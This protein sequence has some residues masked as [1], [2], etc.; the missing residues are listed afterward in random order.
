MPEN[1]WISLAGGEWPAGARTVGMMVTS[2]DGTT[3]ID[4]HVGALTGPDDQEVL[5]GAREHADVV[6]AGAAT[7]AAEGYEGL[8]G[9]DAKAR[10]QERGLRPEPILAI[11]SLVP[12]TLEGRGVFSHPGLDVVVCSPPDTADAVRGLGAAHLATESIVVGDELVPDTRALVRSLARDHGARRIV[13]EGGPRVLGWT[14]A[15]GG[16]D[17]CVV[18]VSPLIH[19]G[20]P[21]PLTGGVDLGEHGARMRVGSNITRGDFIFTRYETKGPD[22][23]K[24]A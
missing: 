18:V 3:M 23:P 1:L 9:D 5:I 19:G 8:L 13:V 16:L 6:I 2:I 21:A 22:E 20:R 15:Q 11:V 12:Q 4:G 7:V 17:Q 10:R 24:T 14:L